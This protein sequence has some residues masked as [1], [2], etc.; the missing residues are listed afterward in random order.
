MDFGRKK[1]KE[2]PC[3]EHKTRRLELDTVTTDLSAWLH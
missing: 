2:L 1:Q 3:F